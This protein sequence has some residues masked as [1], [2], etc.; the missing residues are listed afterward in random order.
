MPDRPRTDPGVP[1]FS[2]GL[3][4]S[5]RFRIGRLLFPAVRLALLNPALPRRTMF[6]LPA[7]YF[8]QPLPPVIG[9]T[10]SEYLW[11]DLT[12]CESSAALLSVELAYLFWREMGVAIV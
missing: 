9:A 11:A 7:T 4:E 10:V 12:P 2:T 8:R 6:P 5:T 1:F 3:F